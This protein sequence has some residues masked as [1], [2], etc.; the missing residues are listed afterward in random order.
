[1]AITAEQ[2]KELRDR[3]G[4]GIMDCKKI[5]TEA[6]GNMDKAIELLKQ[7]GMAKAAKKAGRIAAEGLVEA[8]IH[9]GK[10]GALVEVNS[11]TDFVAT[12]DEF[13]SFVK[14]VAMHV[15]AAAPQ[16][17]KREDVPASIVDAEK[18]AQK[19]KAVAEGKPEAIAEKIVEGRMDKFYSEICLLDQPFVKDPDKTVGQL[20]TELVARIGENIVIRRFVRFERGEGIEKKEENFAEEVM[21][22]IKG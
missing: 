3:T 4:A 1:M 17:V 16:Y 6:E 11:E 15:A 7:K 12:N 13:K 22:Q 9:N 2:V 10:Y 14:D 20:L 8:Y 18:K 21:K 5:L 19:E